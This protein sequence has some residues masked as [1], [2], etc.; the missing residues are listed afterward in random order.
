M[1]ARRGRRGGRGW[2]GV[3]REEVR[4]RLELKERL[5]RSFGA[6]E[7]AGEGALPRVEGFDR[8]ARRDSRG[9]S[10]SKRRGDQA[11]ASR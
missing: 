7:G 1:G 8:R 5:P 4:T 11:Q 10:L 6:G 9:R 2:L 3:G